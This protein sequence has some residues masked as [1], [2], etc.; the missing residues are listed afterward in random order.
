MCVV[1]C[2]L[3]MCLATLGRSGDAVNLMADVCSYT[4]QCTVLGLDHSLQ[5]C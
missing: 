2:L 4:C 1:R 5:V 3:F